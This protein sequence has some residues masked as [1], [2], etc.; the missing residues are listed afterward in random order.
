MTELVSQEIFLHGW[1]EEDLTAFVMQALQP[2]DT[3]YDVGAHLGYFS[4]VAS[5]CVGETGQVLAFEPSQ[6]TYLQLLTPNVEGLRN[7][8]RH[9]WAIWNET[10]TLTLRDYGRAH[11][12]FNT[13]TEP[14]LNAARLRRLSVK[15][16]QVKAVTLDDLPRKSPPPDFVKVDV[17]SAELQVIQ[18][19]TGLLKS[20]KPIVTLEMGDQGGGEKGLVPTSAEVLEA[21][22]KAGYDLFEPKGGRLIAH[23]IK[24]EP[25]RYMNMV[26]LPKTGRLRTR[27]KKLIDETA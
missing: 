24:T 26:C 9:R 25:Y 5:L 18:G 23:E 22:A 21:I 13:L 15:E 4:N 8:R 11:S 27:L 19:M 7:V 17:E 20:R 6:R 16:R 1:F 2:G 12:A 14:K 3:F 10:C